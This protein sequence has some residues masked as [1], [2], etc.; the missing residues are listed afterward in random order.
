MGL[1]VLL[2]G[3]LVEDGSATDICIVCSDGDATSLYNLDSVTYE[4]VSINGDTQD[5]SS[6]AIDLTQV[7]C[8]FGIKTNRLLSYEDG[9]HEFLIEVKITD[10]SG[11][12]Q[13][14]LSYVVFIPVVLNDI[15]EDDPTFIA[16]S[17]PASFT[18]TI[19]ESLPRGAVC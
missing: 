2:L 14:S 13:D 9:V 6:F 3:V 18:I 8:Q 7:A 4:I 10:N 5:T 19:E 17:N 12:A 16:P 1:N 11:L 15:N